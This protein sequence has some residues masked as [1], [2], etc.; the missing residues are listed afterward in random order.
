MSRTETSRQ[1]RR[2]STD[3]ERLLW[4]RLRDR[5]LAGAKFRRQHPIG[6]YIVDFLCLEQRLVIELDG[7]QH[8]RR[9]RQDARRDQWLESRGYRILRFWNSDAM[10]NVEGVLHRISEVLERDA[11]SE[12]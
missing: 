9:S 5:Q 7:G 6:P 11:D 10:R 2:R 3:V 12:P 4:R 1:L 8:A